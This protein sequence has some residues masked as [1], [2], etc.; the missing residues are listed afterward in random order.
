MKIS[1]F[2]FILAIISGWL[3]SGWLPIWK[4]P[5]VPPHLKEAE[6]ASEQG[7][8]RKNVSFSYSDDKSG[9]DVIIK[10]TNKTDEEIDKGLAGVT[11]SF[12]VT[13]TGKQAKLVKIKARSRKDKR[14]LAEIKKRLKNISYQIELPEIGPVCSE[15]RK[16]IKKQLRNLLT[17]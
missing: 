1:K 7:S 12:I 3:F 10:L 9:K 17:Q 4:R 14:K 8:E 11:V 6:A 5:Q 13:D 16:E 15:R 2:I